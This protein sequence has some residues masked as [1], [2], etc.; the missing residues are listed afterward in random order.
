VKKQDKKEQHKLEIRLSICESFTA[1]SQPVAA[2]PLE[3]EIL[4]SS[5][6]NI[7][8]E[9]QD[10]AKSINLHQC[11]RIFCRRFF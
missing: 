3:L 5:F 2:C 1:F 4:L 7:C 9:S 6:N 11:K 10:F 8:Q